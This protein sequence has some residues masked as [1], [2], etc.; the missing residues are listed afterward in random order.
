MIYLQGARRV[1]HETLVNFLLI[2]Q[3]LCYRHG[4][5]QITQAIHQYR[6]IE[7]HISINLDLR[8]Y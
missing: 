7:T 5:Y 3:A 6:N 2:I 4:K 8:Y 1:S